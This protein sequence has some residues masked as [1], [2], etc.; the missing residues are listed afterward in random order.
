VWQSSGAAPFETPRSAA[1]SQVCSNPDFDVTT[2]EDMSAE[3]IRKD[4]LE[5][6]AEHP[7][8][9]TDQ[10]V[11]DALLLLFRL[12]DEAIESINDA[13]KS[14]HISFSEAALHTG[15]VTQNELD[16]ATEWVRRQSLNE[17]RGIVEEALRRSSSSR[18]EVVVWEGERLLPGKEL[19]LA[20][21]PY[22]IRSETIRSLRTELLMRT[23]GR[24]GAAIFALLSCDAQEGRSQLCAELAIAFAQ[25]GSRTLLV[26]GD[27]R[28]PRQHLLFG[29]DNQVGLAQVLVDGGATAARMH[30]IEGVAQMALLTSGAPPPNPLELLSSNRFDRLVADWR[31]SYEFV[32]IDTPPASQFSDSLPVATAAGNVV[33]LGKTNATSFKALAELQRKLGTTHARVVG[34]VINSF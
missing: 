13:Q 34:A 25:L 33:V 4:A 28:R 26:D 22:N 21:D 7:V 14:L 30:G 24:R 11:A 12:P 32:V 6:T 10:Q 1:A 17:G 31:R 19:V 5:E 8:P 2:K 27:M 9:G 3:P 23:N 29:A 16:Q 18:R 20:H 15:L